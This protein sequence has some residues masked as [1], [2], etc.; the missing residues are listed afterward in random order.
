MSCWLQKINA[1]SRH[2]KW[3]QFHY[4]D[5]AWNRNPLSWVKINSDA[6]VEKSRSNAGS[7]WTFF[8]QLGRRGFGNVAIDIHEL[9]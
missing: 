2:Y 1:S 6:Y 5:K 8:V 7:S 3:L 9:S 4:Q